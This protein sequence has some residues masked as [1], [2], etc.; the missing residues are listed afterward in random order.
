M[1]KGLK[2]VKVFQGFLKMS[3][4]EYLFEI[5]QQFRINIRNC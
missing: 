5:R 2:G 4:I 1:R 3:E